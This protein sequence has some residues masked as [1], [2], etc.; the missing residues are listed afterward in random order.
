MNAELPGD[1]ETL[2]D[3]AA[4]L[5]MR[6]QLRRDPADLEDAIRHF[7]AALDALP[8]S[9]DEPDT[10]S[11]LLGN[12][13]AALREL[14]E[15]GKNPA[16]LEEAEAAGRA[17]LAFDQPG[18]GL[19]LIKLGSLAAVLHT[20]YE[21]ANDPSL[22]DEE[23]G[24][25]QEAVRLAR[26]DHPY[27]GGYLANLTHA[28]Y[29]R[30][31]T[32]FGDVDPDELSAQLVDYAR[33][34]VAALP[35]D[36]RGRALVVLATVLRAR[37]EVT[38]AVVFLWE[39]AD[40]ARR[41]VAETPA[42]HVAR[43]GTLANA[44]AI[45]RFLNERTG[46]REPLVE[47]VR[48]L[49]EAARI[50]GAGEHNRVV[51][52]SNLALTL[53]D[54]WSHS[55]ETALLADAMSALQEAARST[56]PNDVRQGSVLTNLVLVALDLAERTGDDPGLLEIAEQAA[57]AAVEATPQGHREQGS[58]L[59][60]LA[61]V[62]AERGRSA[63]DERAGDALLRAAVDIARQALGT[64][65]EPADRA[66]IR[67]DL[68]S[69]LR[70]SGE[71]DGDLSTLRKAVETARAAEA[72]LEPGDPL[73]HGCRVNLAVALWALARPAEGE[74]RAAAFDESLR[75]YRAVA[76][77]DEA[78]SMLRIRC[79]RAVAELLAAS[80]V[81]PGS[82]QAL[83]SIEAAVELL[84]RA[85]APH[86]PRADREYAA[87]LLA[88]LPAQ[89]ASVAVGAGRPERAVELAEYSRGLLV[90]EMLD[91]RSGHLARA[92]RW[93]EAVESVERLEQ[94]RRR[95]EALE[96]EADLHVGRIEPDR[97]GR[98]ESSRV[99]DETATRQQLQA[100]QAQLVQG[101]RRIAGL[102]DFL[103]P[104][105]FAGVAGAAEGGRLVYVYAD[106][107]R[108][109]ALLVSAEP[110]PS[111]RVIPL[112]GVTLEMVAERIQLVQDSLALGTRL[113]CARGGR[114]RRRADGAGSTRVDVGRHR[115]TRAGR[116]RRH[117][118]R[119]GWSGAADLVVP[120]RRDDLAAAARGRSV[121]ARWRPL[122]AR[123]RRRLVRPLGPRTARRAV[124]F[125]R[126]RRRATRGGAARRVRAEDQ[127][128][129]RTRG[130]PGRGEDDRG[131]VPRHAPA[132]RPGAQ[133]GAGGAPRAPHR[134]LRL[135]RR[136][137]PRRPG[138]GPTDPAGPRGRAADRERDQQADAARRRARVP[139]GLRDHGHQPAAGRRGGAPDRRVP[140]ERVSQGRGNALDGGRR[141]RLRRRRALL[142]GD[143]LRGPRRAGRRGLR[144]RPARR[145]AR[146]PRGVLRDA[147]P[148]G[149]VRA[150]RGVGPSAVRSVSA[151][152]LNPS[153]CWRT[154]H[155]EP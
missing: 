126:G 20:R 86:L 62:V 127:G 40:V 23:I 151:V 19:R 44:A 75:I 51:Y 87:G 56:G 21:V 129:R 36:D 152:P 43:A 103:R 122:G 5:M 47:A 121:C 6:Y 97:V 125:R 109:D 24:L 10:R 106:K 142:R 8:A 102:E 76:E 58:R 131:A 31:S 89:A 116:D 30:L 130:S 4:D 45:L 150:L 128:L 53:R 155:P 123:P 118:W 1:P 79:H 34:A 113:R 22:L 71:R 48:Y 134:P 91:A 42:G 32:A 39:A 15:R 153:R 41:G 93:P 80:S 124:A 135:P 120:D 78:P 84:P 88:G 119:V 139:L 81:G 55:G 85:V 59:M 64:R 148:L 25:L 52:L 77:A 82:A 141:H 46:A 35:A 107:E 54:Q 115:G 69:L 50:S 95:V 140:P 147:E 111:V 98:G 100:E 65:L 61:L 11:R 108:C 74:E 12:L 27:L 67:T 114:G 149:R 99:E 18:D 101:V 26:P 7:R 133:D 137:R 49:R 14:Y 57:R 90:A 16:V 33:E 38:G 73:V 94:L 117:R 110:E 96:Q 60:N 72:D 104:P 112:S 92:R 28:L 2:N 144:P 70:E 105:D 136:G 154:A 9:P 146:R 132:A 83:E 63:E 145:A 29:T 13:G 68:A 17:S 3:R 66:R 143:H 138:K 37:S